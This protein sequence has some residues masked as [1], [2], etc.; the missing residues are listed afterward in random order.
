MT[1]ERTFVMV[2]PDG[3]EKNVIG[4]CL[5][6]L[7]KA[8]L[9]LLAGRLFIMKKPQAAKL[10]KEHKAK[11]FYPELIDFATSG[12][13][14]IAVFEGENAVSAV[15]GIAGPTDPKKAPKGTIRGD[16]GTVLPLT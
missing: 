1:T 5:V 11:P 2:K 12:P 15:R 9:K 8:G 6:R 4:E 7:E 16:F 14:F 10:Y 13:A 3:V